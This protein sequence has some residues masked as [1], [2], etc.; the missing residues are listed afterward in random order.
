MSVRSVASFLQAL[1]TF[2]ILWLILADGAF[3]GVLGAA[4]VVLAALVAVGVAGRKGYHWRPLGAL[5]FLLFFLYRSVLGALD[6][7]YRAIHPQRA[8]DPRWVGH[9]LQL[10]PGEPR[11]MMLSALSLL[12]GTLAADLH[13]DHL[14]VHVLTPR[15]AREILWLE[16]RV[17]AVYGIGQVEAAT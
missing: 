4:T 11:V 6:V 9:E 16:A 13:G 2:G 8:I 3:G 7:G 17:A 5:Q 1:L 14:L 10:P 15:A 12:P